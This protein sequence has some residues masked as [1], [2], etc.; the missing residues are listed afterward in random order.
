M[1]DTPPP[2]VSVSRQTISAVDVLVKGQGS[3][4]P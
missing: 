3:G 2:L 4:V 1:V